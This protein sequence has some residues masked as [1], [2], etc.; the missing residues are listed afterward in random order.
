MIEILRAEVAE[1]A[2]E[3]EAADLDWNSV[4]LSVAV[5]VAVLIVYSFD[6]TFSEPT[7]SELSFYLITLELSFEKLRLRLKQLMMLWE[8]DSDSLELISWA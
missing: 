1:A 2:A 3:A 6:D 5:A 8:V 4:L 7:C